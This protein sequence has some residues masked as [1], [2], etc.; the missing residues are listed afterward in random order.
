MT[1]KE[2]EEDIRDF[3]EVFEQIFR[4]EYEDVLKVSKRI[5]K[6]DPIREQA[7]IATKS[8]RVLLWMAADR[9]GRQMNQNGFE[10]LRKK[11]DD[12]LE[13]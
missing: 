12:L 4:D 6:N 3:L 2:K 11:I 1:K 13:R 9:V 7:D 10:N 5:K 8:S